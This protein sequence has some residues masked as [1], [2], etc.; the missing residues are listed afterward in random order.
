[1]SNRINIYISPDEDGF[2]AKAELAG[3]F[4]PR[5]AVVFGQ[6]KRWDGNNMVGVITGSQWIDEY[7]YRTKGGRWVRCNDATRYHNGSCT[8]EFVTDAQA[9][10]WL[11]RS[12]CNDEAVAKYFGEIEEERGPGRPEV[13]PAIHVRL[14]D[15]L[16]GQLDAYASERGLNRAEAVRVL[17]GEALTAGQPYTVTLLDLATRV[18]YVESQ[19]ASLGAAVKALREQEAWDSENNGL[20]S[21]QPRVEHDGR[22]VDVEAFTDY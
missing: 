7:L 22:P 11:L 20:P 17:L 6:D 4:D 3:W 5:S 1:M 12:E 21:I 8:Y 19:H 15:D 14:G 2:D 9:K 18:R 13:G 10:D 16:L